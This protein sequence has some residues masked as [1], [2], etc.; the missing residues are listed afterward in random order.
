MQFVVLGTKMAIELVVIIISLKRILFNLL[1][2][3]GRIDTQMG[4][5][6]K[7]NLTYSM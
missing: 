4:S 7:L 3:Q 5:K 1:Y 2:K 6:P